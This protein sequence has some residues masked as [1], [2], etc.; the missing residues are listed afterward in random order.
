MGFSVQQLEQNGNRVLVNGTEVISNLFTLMGNGTDT[1]QAFPFASRNGYI[2]FD[3]TGGDTISTIRIA[4]NLG[5]GFAI[6]HLAFDTVD[7]V[8]TPAP[9]G[10]G[11]L[12][13]GL[14]LLVARRRR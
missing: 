1:S 6:D 11:L 3:A 2:R 7:T 12:G 10:V 9:A 5:D 13:M 4:N 8:D 14:A